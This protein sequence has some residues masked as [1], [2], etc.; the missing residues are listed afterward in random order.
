M[1]SIYDLSTTDVSYLNE[2]Q[3]A[4]LRNNEKQH[5]ENVIQGN[6]QVSNGDSLIAFYALYPELDAV[7]DYKGSVSINPKVSVYHVKPE[8]CGNKTLMINGH[9]YQQSDINHMNYKLRAAFF[10]RDTDKETIDMIV[11]I[12]RDRWNYIHNNNLQ[13]VKKLLEGYERNNAA[14]IDNQITD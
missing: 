6:K 9:Q 13:V 8:R 5:W 1:Y 3:I 7:L 4:F 10:T 2:K 12:M 11:S 14:V